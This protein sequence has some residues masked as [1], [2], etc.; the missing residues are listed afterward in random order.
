MKS[1]IFLENTPKLRHINLLKA[2][3]K[4]GEQ[5]SVRCFFLTYSTYIP[6]SSN[7]L[8]INLA[9]ITH[10]TRSR[11]NDISLND[12]D[13]L[14]AELIHIS[15]NYHSLSDAISLEFKQRR[16]GYNN[17]NDVLLRLSHLSDVYNKAFKIVKSALMPGECPVVLTSNALD[18]ERLL[19]SL[20]SRKF[21]FN[22]LYLHAI[23]NEH[24]SICISRTMYGDFLP[25]QLYQNNNC[26]LSADNSILSSS[27][28]YCERESLVAIQ[29][30]RDSP[31]SFFLQSTTEIRY[32][33]LR[34]INYFLYR[35][36]FWQFLRYLYFVINKSVL[37]ALRILQ[38]LPFSRNFCCSSSDIFIGSTF[39]ESFM[40]SS[41]LKLDQFQILRKLNNQSQNTLYFR[42]HP[43]SYKERL[44]VFDLLNVYLQGV[45]F[46]F[47]P[48]FDPSKF[49]RVFSLSSSLIYK[50][51][52]SLTPSF[53]SVPGLLKVAGVPF[54][55]YRGD[56]IDYSFLTSDLYSLSLKVSNFVS[57]HSFPGNLY[58]SD[59]LAINRSASTFIHLAST[60]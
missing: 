28:S 54:V 17:I 59:S 46:D 33:S 37:Y 20:T 9:E 8:C 25:S 55:D 42:P 23:P 41:H 4:Y 39:N 5:A 12:F 47:A 53:I 44:L 30:R 48:S 15:D 2:L 36:I 51:V 31:L 58:Y 40:F 38:S 1:L 49:S 14:N 19:F 18:L 29:A 56:N 35:I 32:N 21:D 24:N 10:C 22:T 6:I 60:L 3:E 43:A 26:Q 11:T 52:D 50:S 7:T 27:F 34:S 13:D 16:Y 57:G 45:K